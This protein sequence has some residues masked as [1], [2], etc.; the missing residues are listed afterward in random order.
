MEHKNDSSMY[1]IHNTLMRKSALMSKLKVVP[2]LSMI[3]HTDEKYESSDISSCEEVKSDA[4][5]SLI[6]STD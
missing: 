5:S 4:R 1:E 3:D 2:P 6:D